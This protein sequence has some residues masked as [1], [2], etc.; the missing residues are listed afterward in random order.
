APGTALAVTVTA[1]DPFGN[2]ANYRGTVRFSCTDSAATL[3]ADY[4]F[5]AADG[6]VHT[7]TVTLRTPGKQSIFVNDLAR[8]ALLGEAATTTEF[9][10]PGLSSDPADITTGPDG[11]LWFAELAGKI[12]RITPRAPSRSFPSRRVATR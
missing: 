3:P 4:T 6:G 5:T 8:N 11:N 9:S 12:G 10:L 7:F 2:V 1:L